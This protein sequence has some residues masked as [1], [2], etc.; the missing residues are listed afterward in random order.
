MKCVCEF[1]LD[2]R[3]ITKLQNGSDV[4]I[5][6]DLSDRDMQQATKLVLILSSSNSES[7]FK[8][9]GELK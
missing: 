8:V 9:N 3:Q 7:G 4:G 1:E 6:Y 2:K 5:S